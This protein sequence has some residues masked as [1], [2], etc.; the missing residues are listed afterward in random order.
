VCGHPEL[1]IPLHYAYTEPHMVAKT[2]LTGQGTERTDTRILQVVYR[3]ADPGFPLYTG[4]QLQAFIQANG[5]R[6]QGVECNQQWWE[7]G[8]GLGSIAPVIR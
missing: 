4:Q 3:L 7:S 8:T 5:S 2:A 6:R 1:K